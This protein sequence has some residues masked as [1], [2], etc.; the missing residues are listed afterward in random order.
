MRVGLVRLAAVAV[1]VPFAVGLVAADAAP[2][3]EVAFTFDDPEIVESSGLVALDGPDDLV[4]TVN[5]SG[6]TGRVFVVDA[7]SGDT[8]GTTVFS[9]GPT[10]V[11]A[12]APAGG[13]A[14]WVA[15]IGDNAAARDTVSVSRVP[16]GRGERS[17]DAASY[18]LD[19]PGPPQ[20]AETLLAEPGTGR[21]VVVTK[22][23]FGG[24]VLLGP[25]RLDPDGPNRMRRAGL[26]MGIATDGAF[27]SDGRHLV[28]RGYRSATVYTWPGLDEV[29][30]F[31]LPEQ[32][33]G[34][35]LA[36]EADG[37]L[38]LSTEGARSEVLRV[39]LPER[40][41]RAVAPPPPAPPADDDVQSDRE[42]DAGALP[43]EDRPVWPWALGGVV[44][45]VAL[46]VLVRSLRPR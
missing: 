35:G 23:V 30:R 42:P 14:V 37:A 12:I 45:V 22:G 7:G 29:G 46:A 24:E 20:D 16:V 5:D 27:L 25:R 1:T 17:V 33:Q 43:A 11:E 40:I 8:V 3:A 41:A 10:D 2:R 21:L 36:V 15:D 4:A 34:E 19:Y 38:L 13:G 31:D 9:A 44:G 39:R 26:A 18:E 32:E 6:D 28:V